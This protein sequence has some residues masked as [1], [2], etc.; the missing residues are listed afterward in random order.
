MYEVYWGCILV[1]IIFGLFSLL[2]GDG[3]ADAFDGILDGIGFDGMD[4]LHPMTILSAVVVFGG[5]GVLLSD[6]SGLSSLSII[7][8][9][10]GAGILFAILSFFVYV[11]PMKRTE[12][13]LGYSVRELVGRTAAVSIPIPENGHGEVAIRIGSQVVYQIAASYNGVDIPVDASVVI[14]EFEEGVASV[15]P[16][17]L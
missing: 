11:R 6:Y 7:L 4:F 15:I 17:D 12:S 16:S 5:S 2:F 10:A 14:V 1:G 8:V 3:I 13:S 9:S